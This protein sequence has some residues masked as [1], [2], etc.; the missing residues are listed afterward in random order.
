LKEECDIVENGVAYYARRF[1]IR[2]VYNF[3]PPFVYLNT[4]EK[5]SFVAI[6]NKDPSCRKEIKMVEVGTLEKFDTV[7][8]KT[9]NGI[10]YVQVDNTEYNRAVHL[11]FLFSD[12]SSADVPVEAKDSSVVVSL[13]CP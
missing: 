3:R 5:V 4:F 11:S 10:S 6:V 8:L 12:R 2:A 13:H 9:Y 1:V 7:A